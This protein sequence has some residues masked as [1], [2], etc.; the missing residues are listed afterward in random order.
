M[1]EIVSKQ[2]L[3][4]AIASNNKSIHSYKSGIIDDLDCYNSYKYDDSYL[5]LINHAVLIVGYGYDEA[6]KTGYW[7]IK[8]SWDTTWGDE[9]YFKVAF[10]G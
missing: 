4:V 9:G 1:L 3:A 5:D 2:P 10:V 8:N 6:K 7:L